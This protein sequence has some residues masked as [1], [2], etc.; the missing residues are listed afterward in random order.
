MSMDWIQVLLL[1]IA[2]GFYTC[3]FL[4]I[5]CDIVKRKNQEKRDN[6]I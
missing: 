5:W 1:G 4:W 3:R 6:N 2:I